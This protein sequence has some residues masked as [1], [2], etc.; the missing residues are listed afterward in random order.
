MPFRSW[1]HVLWVSLY[2][3]LLLLLSLS[4]SLSPSLSTSLRL[5]ILTG[6]VMFHSPWTVIGI[7][8]HYVI[9]KYGD[10][11]LQFQ[12]SMTQNNRWI[13]HKVY[14]RMTL[15]FLYS[16]A[17][18]TTKFNSIFMNWRLWIATLYMLPYYFEFTTLEAI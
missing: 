11:H 15:M 14:H 4:L 1:R 3:S 9:N 5:H 17:N 7:R 10:R 8:V 2:F 16:V 13:F 18:A 6:Y 12:T